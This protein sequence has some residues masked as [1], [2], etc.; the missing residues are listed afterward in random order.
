MLETMTLR[1]VSAT[2]ESEIRATHVKRQKMRN[3]RDR[4]GARRLE[5]PAAAC[6]CR[7]S[8]AGSSLTCLGSGRSAH[9][10]SAGL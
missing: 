2:R 8:A 10:R 4:A 7:D 1:S 3:G 6:R 5:G 9:L